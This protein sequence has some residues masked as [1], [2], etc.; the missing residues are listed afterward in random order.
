MFPFPPRHPLTRSERDAL[1]R[2]IAAIERETSGEVRIALHRE[3]LPAERALSLHDLALLHFRRMGMDRTE[4][5]TGVLLF[6][7]LDERKLQILADQGIHTKVAAGT[8]DGVA[9]EMSGRFKDGQLAGGLQAG[10]ERVGALLKEH[11]PRR[12]GDRNELPDGVDVT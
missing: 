5:G 6:L 8:W 11:F 12:P 10:L 1:A 4:C 3:R 7:L 9:A 2:Q